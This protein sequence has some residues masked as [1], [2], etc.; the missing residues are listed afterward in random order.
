MSD[1]KDPENCNPPGMQSRG[2]P[3]RVEP[4]IEEQSEFQ[5]FWYPKIS[6]T[7]KDFLRVRGYANFISFIVSELTKHR[8]EE[9]LPLT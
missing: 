5:Y 3:R 9:S 7:R 1:R 4:A 6:P 2:Y 8:L